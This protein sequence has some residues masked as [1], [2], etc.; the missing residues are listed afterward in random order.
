MCIQLVPG[1]LR[2]TPSSGW[3]HSIPS[4]L[5]MYTERR[6]GIEVKVDH[7]Q[8]PGQAGKTGSLGTVT[9]T[10]DIKLKGSTPAPDRVLP[11]VSSWCSWPS[12]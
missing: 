2:A 4:N 3:I 1:L 7:R 8:H 6:C 12:H 5:W 11:Q 10:S 9:Y